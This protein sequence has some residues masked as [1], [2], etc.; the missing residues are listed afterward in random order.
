MLR[1]YW[2]LKISRAFQICWCF[3]RPSRIEIARVGLPV[4]LTEDGISFVS[5][6][7]LIVLRATV[8]QGV[9][10]GYDLFLFV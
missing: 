8:G 5:E 7:V 9:W 1:N 2:L 3:Y 4:V 10:L 6:R